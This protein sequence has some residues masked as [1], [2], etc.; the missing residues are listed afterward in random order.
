MDSQD[1]HPVR[2]SR[3][4]SIRSTRRPSVFPTTA[5]D[6]PYAMSYRGTSSGL[7]S[8]MRNRSTASLWNMAAGTGDDC[9]EAASVR[10]AWMR[11]RAGDEDDL[12]RMMAEERRVSIIL[13]GPQ[14][15]SHFLIGSENR[16]HQW[17]RYWKTES[18]LKRFKRP[19]REYYQRTNNL[20]R[21]YIFIDRLLDSSIPHDL[22]ND[23]PAS[24]SG[25]DVP[26][27]ISEEPPSPPPS[28]AVP[29]SRGIPSGTS[30]SKRPKR[31]P[32]DIFKDPDPET[33]PL[34]QG[35]ENDEEANVGDDVPKPYIPWLEDAELDHDDPIVT[36]AIWVNIVA[37]IILLIG[38]V[39][40][41]TSVPSMSVMASLVDAVLDFL[42]TAI[43]WT[44]TRLISRSQTDQYRYPVGRRRLVL[45]WHLCG[46]RVA[47][48]KGWLTRYR[49]EPVGVLVFSI[50]MITSFFQVGLEC[51]SRLM[52][53]EHR[54]LE[55]YEHHPLGKVV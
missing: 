1:L 9:D 15:R 37:N 31:M 6:Y 18:E 13:S 12:R 16:K 44:T 27:T 38:K 36:W 8:M 14:M 35:P 55:L 22:L 53:P 28:T 47:M 52:S 17:E 46:Y 39:V 32:K 40:V 33:V 4:S 24:A 10:N 34:L 41:V 49:L 20:I 48:T 51:V 45:W 19:I 43:V 29:V 42:S 11:E 30:K 50:I 54:I 5:D 3:P 2:S 25:L 23:Y 21:Q 7:A 26:H